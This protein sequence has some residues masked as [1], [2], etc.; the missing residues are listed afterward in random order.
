MIIY[1]QM[2]YKVSQYASEVL[3]V[4][5]MR[6]RQELQVK[7]FLKKHAWLSPCC[8]VAGASAGHAQGQGTCTCPAGQPGAQPSPCCAST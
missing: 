3:H 4:A 2:L 5:A 1:M 8:D 6:E 7:G